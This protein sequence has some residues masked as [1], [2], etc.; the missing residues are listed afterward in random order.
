LVIAK[1]KEVVETAL[2]GGRRVGETAPASVKHDDVKQ[3][4]LAEPC[5]DRADQLEQTSNF[6]VDGGD[7][8][9]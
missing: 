4:L 1:A 5:S 9:A 2:N 3:R 8:P 6:A 7:W